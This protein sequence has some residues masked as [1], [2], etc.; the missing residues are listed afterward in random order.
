MDNLFDSYEQDFKQLVA[1]VKDKLEKD[2]KE[3]RGEKLKATL[4]RVEMELDEA[5]EMISQ[6]EVEIHGMPQ[7]VKG[8]F[9][10]R[11]KNCKTELSR[12]KKQAKELHQSTTRT[13]L[14]SSGAPSDNPYGSP[15]SEDQRARLLNGT[16]VLSDGTRRL[17]DSHRI[18]LETEDVGADILR[19]LRMQR[20]QIEHTRD[21][22]TETD[23]HIGRASGTLKGMIRRMHKQ[24]IMT[25]G[26]VVVLVLI[27]GFILWAKLS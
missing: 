23:T 6:M 16:Q 22:L 8:Q 9:Q 24:R 14:F 3:Q 12:Y 4:R 18:A 17:E 26:I 13:D 15:E 25:I 5:D 20:G 10:T 2:G 11:V 19:T 21:M 27:I 7:S 1:S